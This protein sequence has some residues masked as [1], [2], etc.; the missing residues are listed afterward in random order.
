MEMRG[1]PESGKERVRL[2]VFIVI[3]IFIIK[4]KHLGVQPQMAR[5]IADQSVARTG[6]FPRLT[7]DR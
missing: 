4:R 2:F 1:K 5:M 6:G 3:L 7:S